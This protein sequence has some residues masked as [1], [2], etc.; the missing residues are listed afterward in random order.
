MSSFLSHRRKAF[1]GGAGGVTL[2]TH[3]WDLDDD[4]TWA[5]QG[6]KAA[7]GW[8]LSE[9]GSVSTT[10]STI[11]SGGSRT[12]LDM[13]S[14]QYLEF[15]NAGTKTVA[16]DGDS[17]DISVACWINYDALGSTGAWLISWRDNTDS[18]INQIFVWQDNDNADFWVFDDGNVTPRVQAESAVED[19]LSS[20]TWYHLVGTFDASAG[21][22]KLYLDGTE[23]A[24]DTDATVDTLTSNASPFAIG[25]GA[26]SKGASNLGYDGKM[27]AC[28]IWD[29]TL[30][31]DDVTTLYNSG[32]G[33]S[34]SEIFT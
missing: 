3:W 32:D 24:T 7:A 11:G 28:G 34:Y 20:G 25:T 4:G 19:A 15:D 13:A 18:R 2:P 23:V 33:G 10:T 1:K 16:W 9:S 29:V 5:D 6:E 30:S 21:I 31:A 22:A 8:D 26:W 12:V 27:H 17:D 14:T